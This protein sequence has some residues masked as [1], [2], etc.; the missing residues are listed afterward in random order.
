M[1]SCVPVS[2]KFFPAVAAGFVPSLA[3]LATASMPIDAIFSG[4]CI[5]VAPMTPFFTLSTP[6]QPPST[7]TIVTSFSRP[8]ALSAWYAPAA[9][10]S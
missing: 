7:E 6:G 3:N 4:N 2:T 10:G 8:A 1:I 5:E 9:A